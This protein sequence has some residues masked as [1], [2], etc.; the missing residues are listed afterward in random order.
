MGLFELI[1]TYN[2]ECS[3]TDSIQDSSFTEQPRT[4]VHKFHTFIECILF[5]YDTYYAVLPTNE[6]RLYVTKKVM[7]LCSLL[8][9]NPQENYDS[10]SY[11]PKIMKKSIIQHGLQQKNYL[12]SLLYLNDLFQKHFMIVYQGKYYETC[13][14]S[15][16]LDVIEYKNE[17]FHFVSDFV[18]EKYGKGELIH[19]P[20]H[21]DLKSTQIYQTYLKPI[22]NYKLNDLQSIANSFNLSETKNGK[23]KTKKE[24]YDEINLHQLP[25]M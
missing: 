16:S 2:Q 5:K 7:E 22:S 21:N 12:S 20:F 4:A 18:K 24:L 8:D 14:K 11:N 9:E 15:Y 19:L 13:L 17:K 3:F 1:T 6:K 10:Y 23:K 25:H